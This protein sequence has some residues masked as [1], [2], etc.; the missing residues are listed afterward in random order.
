MKIHYDRETDAAYIALSDV[1]P[2]GAVEVSEGVNIDLTDDGRIVGIEILDASTKFP[3]KSLFTCE[4][5]PEQLL[6]GV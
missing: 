1:K 2:S 5:D 4:Y 6:S 3:L